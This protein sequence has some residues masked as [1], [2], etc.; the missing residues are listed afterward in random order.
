MRSFVALLHHAGWLMLNSHPI[1]NWHLFQEAYTFSFAQIRASAVYDL[2]KSKSKL[3][4]LFCYDKSVPEED[5][6]KPAG[7]NLEKKNVG[8][9]S[10]CLSC[11]AK[12]AVLC[13]T[14]A[15][16]GLYLDSILES[17]GVIVKVRCLGKQDLKPCCVSVIPAMY[18]PYY[19]YV[20]INS[21][22]H[23]LW[24]NWKHYVLQMWRTRP[25][26]N[27]KVCSGFSISRC[28]STSILCES[29][30]MLMVSIKRSL[31]TARWTVRCMLHDWELRHLL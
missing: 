6:G 27:A 31:H 9:N 8:N 7:L 2:Q 17:Q 5:I 30:V 10:P 3:E 13:A 23:R 21:N 15:G 25:H 14:C 19:V 4:S 24:R 22:C 16:S 1:Q 18:M 29:V 12:G 28:S 20:L 26:M 11:E